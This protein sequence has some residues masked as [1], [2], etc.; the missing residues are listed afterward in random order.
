MKYL[1]VCDGGNV[2]SAALAFVLKQEK[3]REAIAVGRLCVSPETMR[4]LC[5]WAD[6]IVVMQRHM[7][8]SILPEYAAK[9]RA[10]DVGPDRFGIF[11]HP[12]LLPMV[13]T[14]V[15]WLL[16]EEGE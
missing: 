10:V 14:G 4:M 1:C 16:K 3:R 13:R 12:E 5:V 2:R 6:R 8:E 9:V 15:E 7:T 11:I